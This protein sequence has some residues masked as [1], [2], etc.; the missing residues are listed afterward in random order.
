MDRSALCIIILHCPQKLV[1]GPRVRVTTISTPG[2]VVAQHKVAYSRLASSVSH[3]NIV[4]RQ[5]VQCS[6]SSVTD[7]ISVCQRWSTASSHVHGPAFVAVQLHNA[8]LLQ[9]LQSLSDLFARSRVNIITKHNT[10]HLRTC[11]SLLVEIR[12]LY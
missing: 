11:T 10:R 3:D 7:V 1:N 4:R 12:S 9:R 5:A 6:C 2:L 8:G